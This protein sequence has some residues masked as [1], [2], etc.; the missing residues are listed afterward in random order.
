MAA[1][2]ALSFGVE[3]EPCRLGLLDLGQE[4]CEFAISYRLAVLAPAR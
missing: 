4:S 1:S 3:S 2:I